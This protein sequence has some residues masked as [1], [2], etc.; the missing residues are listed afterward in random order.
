ML[1]QSTNRNQSQARPK[2]V[3]TLL[4]L[5]MA[6]IVVAGVCAGQPPARDKSDARASDS[7]AQPAADQRNIAPPVA[8][9]T[10]ALAP[11]LYAVSLF[12]VS[13]EPQRLLDGAPPQSDAAWDVF[14]KTQIALLKSYFVLQL[15]VRDPEI[16]A[17][18]M[19]ESADGAVDL[20]AQRL[21]VGFYPGSEILYVRMRS[22]SEAEADQVVRIVNAVAKAYEEEVI[23][24]DRQRQL[25]ISDLLAR[26]LK[27]L[28]DEITRNME[29]YQEI[30]SAGGLAD[31]AAGQVEQ[32]LDIRR[33][34]RVEEQI[35]R[36]ENDLVELQTGGK[37]GNAK[38]Y[39]E[40]IRQLSKRQQE[41]EQRIIRRS[42]P[43]IDLT[44]RRRELDQLQRLADGMATKLGLREVEA[45][46]PSRIELIQPAVI[47]YVSN[48]PS[49]P[50]AK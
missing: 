37:E 30:S 40:R 19:F 10:E 13:R 50:S 35:M 33:L 17:L 32:Q 38:F 43:S 7:P 47:S 34:E 1:R 22:A 25:A 14:C 26:S 18:P 20:V 48:S 3:L 16:A 49:A 42:E 28:Q 29:D 4:V 21:E 9:T 2:R 5:F 8:T 31:S 27:K 11:G 41:L 39:E 24:R 45:A 12:R 44:R 23:F 6:G 15:A 46:A 36:L